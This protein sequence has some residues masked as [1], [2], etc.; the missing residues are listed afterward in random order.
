MTRC[1]SAIAFINDGKASAL[2]AQYTR[3]EAAGS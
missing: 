2:L 1:S 3:H